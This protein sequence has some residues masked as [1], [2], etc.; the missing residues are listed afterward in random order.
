MISKL[1]SWGTRNYSLAL[2]ASVAVLLESTQLID[3]PLSFHS[4]GALVQKSSPD[5]SL[6]WDYRTAYSI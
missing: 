6:A 3:C 4:Q 1:L 5:Q 2:R